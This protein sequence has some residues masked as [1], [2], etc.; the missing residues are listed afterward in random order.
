MLSFTSYWK[1]MRRAVLRN[2]PAVAKH[3]LGHLWKKIGANESGPNYIKAKLLILCCDIC[4]HATE[5]VMSELS[6]KELTGKLMWK[7]VYNMCLATKSRDAA[8]LAWFFANEPFTP[9]ELAYFKTWLLSNRGKSLAYNL[10]DMPM[11]SSDGLFVD[12]ATFL[13]GSRMIKFDRLFTEPE[14]IKAVKELPTWATAECNSESIAHNASFDLFVEEYSKE[15]EII[16]PTVLLLKT[17]DNLLW[18]QYIAA[19]CQEAG[20][21]FKELYSL[22]KEQGWV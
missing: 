6:E 21:E 4:Y 15:V 20:T 16:E 5:D 7:V 9:Y 17:T 1:A 12:A 19:R 18:T 2:E 11:K 3:C 8:S 14:D 10:I 13:L 22:A